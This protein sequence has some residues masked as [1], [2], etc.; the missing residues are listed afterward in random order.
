[1]DDSSLIRAFIGGETAAFDNLVLR[2]KD[3]V[4][5]LCYRMLGDY[6]EANDSA[7]EVFVKVYRSIKG[8]RQESSFSTWLYRITANTCKNKLVS[9]EFRKGRVMAR[10]DDKK[11][12]DRPGP[13]ACIPDE[14]FSPRKEL[15]KKERA[16]IIQKAIDLLPA[17]QRVMVVLRDIEGLPYGEIAEVTGHALGTIKSKLS[18]ARGELRKKLEGML[19]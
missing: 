7:Q 8:F 16:A 10:L 18:R 4:F 13:A 2:Y 15:E 19:I 6:E 9:S 11:D 14:S 12:G 17:D 5:G 3:K 1:M